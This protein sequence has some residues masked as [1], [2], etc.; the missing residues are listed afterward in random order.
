MDHYWITFRRHIA[1]CVAVLAGLGKGHDAPANDS[2]RARSASWGSR[3]SDGAWPGRRSAQILKS[4]DCVTTY[5][6]GK[7]MR[8]SLASVATP[9]TSYPKPNKRIGGNSGPTM[10]ICSRKPSRHDAAGRI[11][12]LD[13]DPRGGQ[14]P[15]RRSRRLCSAVHPGRA[16]YLGA[17]WRRTPL[18]A[19]IDDSVQDV[20]IACFQAG[21]ALDAPMRRR[22]AF[23]RF[24][25]ASS[26][27][28][29]CS[30]KLEMLSGAMSRRP[31]ISRS[32]R[33]TPRFL[34]SLIAN[35]QRRSCGKL[36]TGKPTTRPSVDRQPFAVLI[37]CGY[38]SKRV[39][40]SERS[41]SA[42]P[43]IAIGCI[44][45][46]PRPGRNSGPPSSKLW[47][48]ITPVP[49]PTSSVRQPTSCDPCSPKFRR[50]TSQRR[51]GDLLRRF[52]GRSSA[53]E[54]DAQL[55]LTPSA[56][57]AILTLSAIPVSLVVKS[58]P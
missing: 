58:L 53:G 8:T 47:R 9:S 18:A 14:R 15:R 55:P 35:G 22:A 7:W 33:G 23:G 45:N 38:V 42:G 4:R 48:F 19:E 54:T 31:A 17:R 40:P 25:T 37:S 46:M 50:R 20:F 52:A 34:E 3:G 5:S 27:I 57:S 56:N 12:V 6:I 26:A 10:P 51:V 1:G 39:C 43:W 49:R 2:E 41:P 32:P 13:A 16:R 44:T 29:L 24:S 11:D 36:P 30:T 21:G 28:S